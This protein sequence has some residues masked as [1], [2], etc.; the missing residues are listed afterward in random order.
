MHQHPIRTSD[1]GGI[2][3]DSDHD[4][5]R[6]LSILEH[7]TRARNAAALAAQRA[8]LAR[9]AHVE[10]RRL[11]DSEL[12]AKIPCPSGCTCRGTQHTEPFG[13]H[14]WN[15]ECGPCDQARIDAHFGDA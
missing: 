7:D 13:M 11:S 15:C 3:A 14:P 5:D 6:L 9:A 4:L 8:R 2:A 1:R 12:L 10:A